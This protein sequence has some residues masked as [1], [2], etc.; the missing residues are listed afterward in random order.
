MQVVGEPFVSREAILAI[1]HLGQVATESRFRTLRTRGAAS[2]GLPVTMRTVGGQIMGSLHLYS[3][4]NTDAARAFRLREVELAQRL[5]ERAEQ[6]ER[7]E[8]ARRV[9]EAVASVAS[10]IPVEDTD[11]SAEMRRFIEARR[12][13]WHALDR[14]ALSREWLTHSEAWLTFDYDSVL[15][16]VFNLSAAVETARLELAPETHVTT[17]Y[18]RVARMDDVVAEVEGADNQALLVPRDDLQ[19]QGLAALGQAVA[20]LREV[21]P[22]GGSYSLPM[23][24][25]A[26]EPADADT[27]SP[28]AEELDQMDDVAYLAILERRDWSWVERVTARSPTTLIASPLP[29]A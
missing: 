27:R 13:T 24:A 28:F 2:S 12:S 9:R 25:V 15:E 22:G 23:P 26:L 21:L 11:A 8:D 7:S 3:A 14:A 4:L 29:V 18:G 10:R 6:I 5:A 1:L 17:F 16:S 20:I 19:R